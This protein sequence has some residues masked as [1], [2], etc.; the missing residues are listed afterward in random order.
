MWDPGA[1][2]HHRRAGRA[3]LPLLVSRG[4]VARGAGQ[5]VQRLSG[6]A[7]RSPGSCRPGSCSAPRPSWK[8]CGGQPFEIPPTE[9]MA[10]HRPDAALHPRLC[11][12]GGRPGRA[13]V[14]LSQPGAQRLR[15]RRAGKRAQALFGDRHG[16]AAA[17]HARSADA[18]LVRR[19]IRQHGAAYNAGLGFYAYLRFHV[20]STKFRRWNMDP[21]VAAR[22]P[23][24]RPSRGY[25][26]RSASRCRRSSSS[27]CSR[28]RRRCPPPAPV[29]AAAARRLQRAATASQHV[30]RNALVL[31]MC[32]TISA[33]A[34]RGRSN[35]F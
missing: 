20:D 28:Q 29:A 11:G 27:R 26:E 21:A 34:K 6:D 25:R 15:R 24:D 33:P 16:A 13:G 19:S 22:M 14:G 35:G 12:P 7:T 1:A 17:D 31:L 32:N 8:E 5:G 9:R 3:G 4:A 2:L 18:D 30:E 10:A 23:A